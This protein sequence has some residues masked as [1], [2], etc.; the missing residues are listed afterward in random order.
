MTITNLN[1][2]WFMSVLKES[3]FTF[4]R[5][6]Y[7]LFWCLLS[8]ELKK[9]KTLHFQIHP[10]LCGMTHECLNC[11]FIEISSLIRNNSCPGVLTVPYVC[12]IMK[13]PAKNIFFAITIFTRMNQYYSIRYDP[14]ISF[15]SE[16]STC[17]SNFCKIWIELKFFNPFVSVFCPPPFFRCEKSIS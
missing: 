13:F 5:L 4:R 2:P 11:S 10:I 16:E 15:H 7:L 6:Y 3:Q 8:Q 14:L 17:N 1:I 12:W 9:K